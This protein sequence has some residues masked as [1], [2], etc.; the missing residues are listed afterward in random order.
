MRSLKLSQG[1]PVSNINKPHNLP[2]VAVDFDGTLCSNK[3]PFIE[4]PNLALI[5]FIKKHFNDYIW[6]LWTCRHDRQLE[7]AVEYLRKEH[8]LLFDCINQNVPWLIEE[9]GD[10]RKVSA[11]Y[12]IDDR[13]VRW[14][15][16]E[17]AEKRKP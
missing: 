1:L 14:T 12:Y 11:D 5:G 2:I 7:Y 4:N 16:L 15:E 17:C 10:C 9:Y 13:N 8:G 6:I 3:Y